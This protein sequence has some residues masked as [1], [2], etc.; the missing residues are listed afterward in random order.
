MTSAYFQ[1]ELS[2]ES[3][4]L[5]SFYVNTLTYCWQRMSMGLVSAPKSFATMWN[6]AFDDKVLSKIKTNMTETEK[7][8]L[9]DTFEEF[10]QVFFDD[11]FVFSKLCYIDHYIMV[12]AVFEAL[13]QANLKISSK[14][15]KIAVTEFSILGLKIDTAQA[16]TF[17]DYN[18]ASSILS[19]PRPSSLFETQS[20][21]YSLQYFSKYLPKIKE[22]SYPLIKL[23]RSKVWQWT[24]I[25]EN[26]WNNIKAVIACDIRLKIPNKDETLYMFSDASKIS[27]SQILFVERNNQ[28]EIVGANSKVFSYVDSLKAPYHKES[29][30]LV[31]GLKHFKNYLLASSKIPQIYTDCRGVLYLSRSKHYSVS[32]FNLSHFISNYS[33]QCQI[34][35]RHINGSYNVLSDLFS[36]SFEQSRFKHQALMTLSKKQSKKIPPISES[37]SLDSE[38]L[39]ELLVTERKPEKGD[40][41]ADRKIRKKAV[42]RPLSHLIKLSAADTPELKFVNAIRSLEQNNDPSIGNLN[43]PIDPNCMTNSEKLKFEETKTNHLQTRQT[44]IQ[45]DDFLMPLQSDPAYDIFTSINS[46]MQQENSFNIY[47]STNIQV[48][49]SN[50]LASTNLTIFPG[51][52]INIPVF[53]ILADI[54]FNLEM[55]S[56]HS[57]IEFY[58]QVTKN[59]LRIILHNPSKLPRE[60]L[61]NS[62]LFSITSRNIATFVPILNNNAEFSDMYLPNV[63]VP[64]DIEESNP[65]LN[66]TS[67]QA[68]LEKLYIQIFQEQ[69][70]LKLRDIDNTSINNSIYQSLLHETPEKTLFSHQLNYEMSIFQSID[71]E[72]FIEL[73]DKDK[74]IA[75]IKTHCMKNAKQSYKSYVIQRGILYKIFPNE[76]NKITL[77]I[78]DLLLK[79]LAQFLHRKYNHTSAKRTYDI[80]KTK[81]YSTFAR[82]RFIEVQQACFTCC[83][84]QRV[85][86]EKQTIGRERTFTA[87]RPR[88]GLSIDIIPSLPST[89]GKMTAYLL[90]T[91]TF[92]SYSWMILLKSKETINIYNA[93]LNSF[94]CLGIPEFVYTDADNSLIP[95]ISELGIILGFK[96]LTTVPYSQH[97]NRCETTYRELKSTLKKIIHNPEIDLQKSEW[98]IALIMALQSYNSCVIADTGVTRQAAFFRSQENLFSFEPEIF[99]SETEVNEPLAKYAKRIKETYPCQPRNL[100]LRPGQVVYSKTRQLMSNQS[101]AMF[102]NCKGPFLVKQ[103][104]PKRFFVRA[105]NLIDKKI[106]CIHYKDLFFPSTFRDYSILLNDSFDKNLL[107][108]QNEIKR[109]KSA[110]SD[111]ANQ[112]SLQA[113]TED[114]K[115]EEEDENIKIN[116][117]HKTNETNELPNSNFNEDEN[118]ESRKRNVKKNTEEHNQNTDKVSDIDRNEENSIDDDEPLQN[119]NFQKLQ[120]IDSL[121]LRRSQRLYNKSMKNA[122]IKILSTR[123]R[124]SSKSAIFKGTYKNWSLFAKKVSDNCHFNSVPNDTKMVRFAYEIVKIHEKSNDIEVFLL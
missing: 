88:Q 40:I 38:T 44:E 109:A 106:Y 7:M 77:F 55:A 59:K 5:T 78:P 51:S 24:E 101:S 68:E 70:Q 73:Q 21:L 92:T 103:V 53:R 27:C 64:I 98:D 91:D 10:L 8:A 22:I 14:K 37:F 13:L 87:I 15:T 96:Y 79:S 1:I 19:W 71:R 111:Y 119:D 47:Y 75:I 17:L 104:F 30:S 93:L 28:L 80:F 49:N 76:N 36:R 116:G 100:N 6:M 83:I 115:A 95:A 85:R 35:L 50:I 97:Q 108:N 86:N 2:E 33:Q 58:I 25:E 82:R 52:F 112:E 72:T 67:N 20:R 43:I 81:Y 46:S 66:V 94:S 57:E 114:K 34:K 42:P 9:P 41:L 118:I 16:E 123:T 110:I 60:I 122:I 117:E 4:P 18:K 45:T 61:K 63:S 32:S 90:I 29:I 105:Q 56:P 113:E 26:S 39:Y 11:S 120:S 121:K 107:L 23:L 3:K 31:L 102:L 99:Q 65:E 12:K 74:F 48:Q 89:R 84:T 62:P 54:P 124:K 69:R